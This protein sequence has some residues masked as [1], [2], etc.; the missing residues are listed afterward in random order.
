MTYTSSSPM[1]A[2]RSTEVA[3][4]APPSTYLRPSISTGAYH[5][6]IEQ[7]AC[8]ASD[9]GALGAVGWPK[10]TRVPVA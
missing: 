1:P 5:A 7:E 10:T 8:T 2:T 3:D 4:H 6:G 9:S